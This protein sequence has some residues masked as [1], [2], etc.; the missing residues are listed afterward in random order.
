MK[1]IH[2]EKIIKAVSNMAKESNFDLGIDVKKALLKS[3]EKEQS[4]IGKNILNQII[5]NQEIARSEEVP[6]CQDTGFA[7]FYIE[8][9][10]E[11]H[12][13]GGNLN[14]AINEGVRK[15]YEEGYLR[16]SIVRHPFDR[17]NTNDNTPAIIYI[18]IVDGDNLK[19][20]MTAKGG[21]SE[22]MSFIKMLKPSDGIE[23]AKDFIIDCVRTAGPNPCPPIIVGIG[24]GGTFEK[25]AYLAKKSLFRE[26][27]QR[28]QLEDIATLEEELLVKINKTGIGP[29]GLGG[30]T[31]A[32]DVHIEIFPTHIAS[33]PVAVNINC[34]A[35]RHKEVI[36]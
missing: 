36:L 19:I 10:Q 5:E 33:L 22:N 9:G 6:I 16:K 30:N 7:V 25:A 4:P 23:G 27:G 8:L 20:K 1:E 14:D 31:T 2:V 15:G 34:H 21:G 3:A 32:L 17:V 11:V 29:Q 28:N 26:V 35:S 18:E 13:V 24:I 12:I